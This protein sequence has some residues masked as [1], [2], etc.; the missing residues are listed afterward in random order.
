MSEEKSLIPPVGVYF[1]MPDETYHAIPLLSASGMKNLLVSP[2]DFWARSWMNPWREEDEQDSEAKTLGKAYHK[3]IL[4]GPAAFDAAYAQPFTCTE[5]GVLD[6]TKAMQ[7]YLK[8]I[9]VKG[10]SGK[11]KDELTAM[12]LAADPMAKLLHVM[13]EDYKASHPGKIFLPERHLRK[14]ELAARMIELHPYLKYYFVGG[15]PEVTVIWHDADFDMLMKARFDYLKVNAIN[16]LKTFANMMNKGIE[17]AVYGAMASGKYH[18]QAALYL[19][20]SD[21]MK[22][23]MREGHVYGTDGIDPEWLAAVAAAPEHC[24]NFLFQQ[25]GPAP[26][27]IGAAFSR[28]DNM[29]HVGV[30]CVFDAVEKYKR[31]LQTFGTD[32]WVDMRDPIVLQAGQYPNYAMDI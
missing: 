18:V 24:F 15:Q 23:L 17:K 8:D 32:P 14:I 7:A 3:R 25:K 22:P 20:A 29:Y 5:D 21:A 30:S 16:D 26:V 11:N 9:G 12:V 6:G 27:S 10:Y 1:G 31:C 4:E 13:E 19:R 2:M 28:D